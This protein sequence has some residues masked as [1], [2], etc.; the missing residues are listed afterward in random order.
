MGVMLRQFIC[1]TLKVRGMSSASFITVF[2]GT[3]I[4]VGLAL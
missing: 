1:G 4:C 2:C 3:V